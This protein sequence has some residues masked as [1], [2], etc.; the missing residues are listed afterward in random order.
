MGK[1]ISNTPEKMQANYTK[2]FG[3]EKGRPKVLG[4]S[5]FI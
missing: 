4:A 5:L 2:K 1:I 3:I